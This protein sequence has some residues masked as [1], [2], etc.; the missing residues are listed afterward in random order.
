MGSLVVYKLQVKM[1]QMEPRK[2]A[3]G[4]LEQDEVGEDDT[5]R[6]L[7]LGD[8]KVGKT[9][10]IS[11]LVSQHFNEKVPAIIHD[12]QIPAEESQEHVVTTI[13]DSSCKY[14]RLC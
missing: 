10:V 14:P 11:T 13:T 9:S 3:T 8:E 12:V 6:V 1:H 7:V 4:A 2:F 5:V